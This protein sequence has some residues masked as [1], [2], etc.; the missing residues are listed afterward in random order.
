MK[1]E[2]T[3]RKTTLAFVIPVLIILAWYLATTYND[4]PTGIL[5]TIPMVGQAFVDMIHSKELQT[6]LL[7][8]LLRVLKGFLGSLVGMFRT[9]R[10]LLTPTITVIR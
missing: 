8:S 5:P 4:I 1:K 2:N 6:D 9:V 7:I 3:A 10:E